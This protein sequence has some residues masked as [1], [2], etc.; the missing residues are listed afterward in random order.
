MIH[1]AALPLWSL[2][3]A[4]C[5]VDNEEQRIAALQIFEATEER[6]R[7]GNVKPAREV[8]EMVWRQRDLGRDQRRSAASARKNSDP[9]LVGQYEWERAMALLGGWKISLT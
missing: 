6:K 8:M 3:L 2:F 5:S 4:G 9:A 1:T 7:F